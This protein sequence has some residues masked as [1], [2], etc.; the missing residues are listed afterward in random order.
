MRIFY[1]TRSGLLTLATVVLGACTGFKDQLLEPQQPAVIGPDQVGSASAAE[2]LRVGAIA[3][4]RSATAGGESTWLLGG[5]MADEWKSGDTFV[6]RNDTDQRNVLADNSQVL[7][8][9]AAL[10]RARGAAKDAIDAM[11]VYMAD[12]ASSRIAQMYWV[13]GFAEMQLSESFCNGTPF[14]I[15]DGGEP[16]YSNPMT[17]AQGY[18]LAMAHVDSGLALIT[19][20]DTLSVST[21]NSL[22][23]TKARIL[24]DQGK[25]T[26]VAAVTSAVPT[27]YRWYDTFAITSGDN[28]IWSLNSSQKRWVVGDSFD[29]SGLI[30]NALPFASAN[31]PRVKVSGT[32]VASPLN[33]AFDNF[34]QFVSQTLYARSDWV[35]VVSGLDARLYEAEAMLNANDFTGMTTVLDTLR[36]S[37]Q[38]L[39][40]AY[41]TPVMSALTEPTTFGEATDLFFREKAFWVFGRGQRLGDLRR[42]IRQYHRTQDNV[43]PTGTF[44][45]NGNPAYGTDVNF[46][47]TTN[48]NPN[49]AWTGCIDRNA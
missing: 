18:D 14:G 15:M 19:G 29:T 39:S 48:E 46:P 37:E 44:H 45:K 27:A 21:K 40:N 1:R 10:H 38:A 47:V 17:N 34:T 32:S 25:F 7:P 42:L 35:P 30:K 43:F 13:M 36:G 8:A 16:N 41:K 9:Y 26:E 20:T 24:I 3:R 23:I 49:P 6:Q 33:R 31:D 2:A 4:L 5:L 12:T 11:V 28:Q 22:L